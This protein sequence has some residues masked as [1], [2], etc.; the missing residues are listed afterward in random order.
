MTGLSDQAVTTWSPGDHQAAIMPV[1]QLSYAQI[2]ERLSVTPEAARALAKRHRLPRLRANDG[3]TLVA[4]DLLEIQHKPLVS[5]RSPRGHRPVPEAVATLAARV[6]ELEAELA[7][8]EERAAGHRADYEHERA[9][10]DDMVAI[11]GRLIAELE[12]MRKLMEAVPPPDRVVTTRTRW[13]ILPARWRR[14]G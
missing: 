7:K 11:Q 8:A 13:R 3:K 4:V 5:A 12:T 10:A 6:A 14:A 2:A 1:E 9:R